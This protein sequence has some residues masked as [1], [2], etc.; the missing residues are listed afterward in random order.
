M[1]IGFFPSI[2]G[3]FLKRIKLVKKV[4]YYS[5]DYFS[6]LTKTFISK[7]FV[8]L[9]KCCVKR[10][11]FV[12]SISPKILEARGRFARYYPGRYR[13]IPVPLCFDESR[14]KYK[15]V[16][17]VERWSVVFVGTSGYF[18]GLHLLIETMPQLIKIFPRIKVKIIG[19]GPWG[20]TQKKV[21]D[22]DLAGH[23]DF[24]GFIKEE[25]ELFD[26]V[27]GCAVG[28]AL[29]VPEDNNPAFFADP[30]KPKLYAFCAVPVIISK[31]PPVAEEINACGAG[32]A[33]DFNTGS[34]VKAMAEILSDDT[35]W[36]RFRKN[37]FDFAARY[38]S[39]RV[40]GPAIEESVKILVN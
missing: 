10:S 29:Y 2:L 34:L 12:W 6:P 32:K 5:I 31:A 8:S 36:N 40:L 39:E 20:D 24:L 13:N 21:S 15:D 4:I 17:A 28:V 30:G 3:I 22:L 25:T 1:G 38:T 14:L 35:E 33:I 7:M 16:S 11:D 9:D 23:F 37:A 18:H 27:S 26:L 19:P